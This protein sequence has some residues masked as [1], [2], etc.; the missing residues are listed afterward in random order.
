MK[1]YKIVL[2]RRPIASEQIKSRENFDKILHD[3]RTLNPAFSKKGWYYGGIGIA[4]VAAII[5][6]NQIYSESTAEYSPIELTKAELI[7]LP[8]FIASSFTANESRSMIKPE[9]ASKNHVKRIDKPEIE[10]TNS[11]QNNHNVNKPI[12]ATSKVEAVVLK[13]KINGVYEGNLSI[14]ELM[15]SPIV[16]VSEDIEVILFK[17][18]YESRMYEEVAT[19]QGNQIPANILS[20]IR[21]LKGG[22]AIS[23][24]NVYGRRANG[25][26]I[27]LPS[28]NLFIVN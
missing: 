24:S 6:F 21:E 20:E 9:K 8:K 22:Q 23:F 12:S 26:Q 13:P 25:E 10:T 17:I 27:L 4:S 2:D 19:V 7:P 1:K 14:S 28:M 11:G 5:A 16:E 15:K 18:S 3:Y